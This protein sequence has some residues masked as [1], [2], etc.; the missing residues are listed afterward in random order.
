MISVRAR[1]PALPGLLTLLASIGC[2]ESGPN[3]VEVSGVITLDGVPVPRLGVQFSPTF[4][5]ASPAY[6]VT[7]ADGRYKLLYSANRTGAMPGMYNVEVQ[8]LEAQFDEAGNRV[9]P[10]SVKLPKKFL[11]PGALT[12]EVRSEDTTIHFELTSK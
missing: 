10:P 4:E 3:L 7:D 1:L 2:G 12:A 9:G 11:T 6:G 8:P 5:K